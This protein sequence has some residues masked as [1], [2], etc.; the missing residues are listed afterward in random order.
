V[1]GREL[2]V[3]AR[4][5]ENDEIRDAVTLAFTEKYNTKGSQKWIRCFAEPHWAINTL[6]LVP[7][8]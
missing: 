5:V 3:F 6:E 2:P 7:A 1:G 4:F 8:G